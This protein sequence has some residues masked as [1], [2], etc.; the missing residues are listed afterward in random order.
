MSQEKS[1]I[2]LSEFRPDGDCRGKEKAGLNEPGF[3]IFPFLKASEK[4]PENKEEASRQKN[5]AGQG[6]DPGGCDADQSAHLNTRA[7]R[8]HGPGDA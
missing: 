5:S 7:V 6:Q 8:G 2:K 1:A 4:V 3:D